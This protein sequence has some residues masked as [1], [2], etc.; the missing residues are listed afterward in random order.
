MAAQ[1]SPGGLIPEQVWD[2]ADIPDRE[3]F[4]GHP[5]GSAM[6]LVWAHAEYVK[7][8]RSLRERR[9]FD[10][11]PQTVQRYQVEKVTSR[12]AIWRFNHKCRR[13]LAGRLLR[14]EVLA[15]ALV[16]WS[17]DD[18]H[19]AHD[20]QTL[21]SG[22]GI[23]VADLPTDGLPIGGVLTF[24]FLWLKESRWEGVNF[25]VTVSGEGC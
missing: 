15:A 13:L 1:T 16:H 2:A 17:L 23:H 22:L 10:T 5:S 8:L 12:L 9:V 25:E 7:L 20:T 14:I 24:T 4:N 11:P 18:W 21:D 3:L 6:P 19:S